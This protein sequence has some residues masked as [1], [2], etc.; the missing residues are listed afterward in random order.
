MKKVYKFATGET[1]PEGAEYL[2]SCKNGSF[3]DGYLPRNYQYVWHYFLV[4]LSEE[5][6]NREAIEK[7]NQMQLERTR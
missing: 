1:V 4:E 6:L 2:Y 7:L 3:P 5:E